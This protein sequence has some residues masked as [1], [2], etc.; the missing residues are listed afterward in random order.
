MPAKKVVSFVTSPLEE[1]KENSLSI[2]EY[3]YSSSIPSFPNLL[4]LA[5]IIIFTISLS[6]EA[7]GKVNEQYSITDT[8]AKSC[9]LDFQDKHC[10]TLSM[11]EECSKIY[12]C[13]QKISD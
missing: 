3:S 1:S 7:F 5:I 12:K 9:M 8:Q 2:S 11:G 6:F 10:N 13:I 4:I